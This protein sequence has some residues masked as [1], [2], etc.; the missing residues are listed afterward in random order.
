M[1][2]FYAI[3]HSDG[4]RENTYR[5]IGSIKHMRTYILALD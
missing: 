5:T 3:N 4:I 1:S 2:M